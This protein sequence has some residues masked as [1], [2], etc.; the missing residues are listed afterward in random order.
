MKKR[1][2]ILFVLLM[3]LSS[4]LLGCGAKEKVD[5]ALIAENSNN[6]SPDIEPVTEVSNDINLQAKKEGVS[7][8]EMQATLDGLAELSAEKYNI[9]KEAYI[10][11]TEANGE[12][13][14]SEWQL[15]SENMGISITELYQYELAKGNTLTDDQKSTMQGMND[16]LKMAEA[17][18]EDIPEIGTSD[19]ENLLGIQGNDSGEIREVFLSDDALR[20]ALTMD[21]Y[22]VL[23]DY[24]DEYSISY[25]YVTDATYEDIKAY[26]I[27]L[28]ENT[29]EYLKLEPMADRGVTLQGTINEM[30]VYIDIN[31]SDPD[32]VMVSTYLD[33]S[34]RP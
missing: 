5:E 30:L 14:L 15:V 23:Q 8:K 29:E 32:K 6:S 9:T 16:A 27:A 3:L 21:T 7:V 11:Q 28:I 22:K 19:I 24:R 20:E 13:V 12:T 33:L 34:S 1:L 17:E 26:Y 4:L 10:V 25:E 18:L 2:V 31:N